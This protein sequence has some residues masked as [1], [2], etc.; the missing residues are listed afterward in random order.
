MMAEK[1]KYREYI[2]ENGRLLDIIALSKLPKGARKA[3]KGLD[4][5]VVI[6]DSSRYSKICRYDSDIDFGTGIRKI[7]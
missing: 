7:G 4:V 1:Y 2:F 3:M 6:K 5:W